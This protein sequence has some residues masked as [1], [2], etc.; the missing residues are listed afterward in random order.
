LLKNIGVFL[1]AYTLAGITKVLRD[2][3]YPQWNRPSYLRGGLGNYI[4]VVAGWMP[5]GLFF[6]FQ[7]RQIPSARMDTLLQFGVF[8]V[9]T[10]F[11]LATLGAT[12]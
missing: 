6:L 10:W 3:C 9:A 4:S 11:G 1:V 7:W 12:D 5:L 8:G 2:M